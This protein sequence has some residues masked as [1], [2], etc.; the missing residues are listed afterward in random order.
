MPGQT[1][2]CAPSAI[3]TR[4]LLLRSNPA[5]DAVAICVAAGQVRSGTHCCSPSYLVIASRDSGPHDRHRGRGMDRVQGVPLDHLIV[6]GQSGPACHPEGIRSAANPEHSRRRR[7]WRLPF[8]TSFRTDERARCHSVQCRA[9]S[10]RTGSSTAS[11]WSQ[12]PR[13]TVRPAQRSLMPNSGRCA[14]A[15]SCTAWHIPSRFDDHDDR[16]NSSAS[17][18]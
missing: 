12:D 4:A 18:R 10:D 8:A 13:S 15:Y 1:S 17:F 16:P 3:R 11:N 14:I 9:V 5:A 2:F 6:P 7:P